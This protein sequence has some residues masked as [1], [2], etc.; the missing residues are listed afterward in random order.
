[1]YSRQES[2]EVYTH[3]SYR[4]FG[5]TGVTWAPLEPNRL[6]AFSSDNCVVPVSV[7][8][9]LKTGTTLEPTAVG[10]PKTVA[11]FV[12][13]GLQSW[14]TDQPHAF[15][16]DVQIDDLAYRR[17]DPEYYAWLRSRMNLAKSAHQAGQ[18]DA[19][20]YE[21]LRSKFNGIHD[22]AM[23]HFG[24]LPLSEAVRTLDARD[25]RPPAA[26]PDATERRGGRGDTV[27]SAMANAAALV[28][29]IAEKALALGWKRERL[30]GTGPLFGPDRG[31]V[32]YLKPDDRTGEVTPQSIEIIGP[33]PS[34]GRQHFYNPDVDQPWIRRVK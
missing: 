15:A 16:R 17:L 12:S 8:A 21:A 19:E 25:Y 5:D 14:V 4:K 2:G 24:A 28:D 33:A 18:I 3:N 23:T 11:V 30:Y 10:D 29:A 34:G 32:C 31:L 22:W 1:M 7:L 13:T 26:E 9:P 20:A 6:T 27:S